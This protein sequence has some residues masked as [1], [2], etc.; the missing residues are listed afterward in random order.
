VINCRK[1][2]VPK[3]FIVASVMQKGQFMIN[4][5]A[6]KFEMNVQKT[7][8]IIHCRKVKPQSSCSHFKSELEMKPVPSF[9]CEPRLEDPL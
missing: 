9:F 2:A 7:R 4:N 6:S 1:Q 8:E 5:N 3:A